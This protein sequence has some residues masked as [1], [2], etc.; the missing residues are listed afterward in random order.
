MP[1][2][3]ITGGPGA[4][5]TSLL[6]ELQELGYSVSEEASRQ[7]II[8]EVNKG[9]N[10]LPWIDLSAFAEK[11]LERM[12][13]LY[14]AAPDN[15]VT[16]FDR[17]I[18]DIIAYLK[19]ASID[20]DAKYYQ[21][22]FKCQYQSKVFILAP[23]ESIYVNDSERWQTFEEAGRLYESIKETYEELGFELIELPRAS[24]KERAEFVVAHIENLVST[25]K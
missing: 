8:E 20:P 9:S 25:T 2:Y 5:K 19:A 6:T 1:K 4:G 13:E 21:A 24:T 18:P 17:G 15:T 12:R 14:F 3:I 10:C 11:A 22:L 16:F 7:L 23:W